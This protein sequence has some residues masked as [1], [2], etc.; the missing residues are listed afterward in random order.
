MVRHTKKH[1][2]Q[3]RRTGTKNRRTVNKHNQR[4]NKHNTLV[5]SRRQRVNPTGTKYM[6]NRTQYGGG[7]G[8]ND[9]VDKKRNFFK[10]AK[11]WLGKKFTRKNR[12]VSTGNT[13][14]NKSNRT[15]MQTP[16]KTSRTIYLPNTEKPYHPYNKDGV[17]TSYEIYK[18]ASRQQINRQ[19]ANQNKKTNSN[20]NT[21]ENSNANNT[22]AGPIEKR[23][24]N[25]RE[26]D[27]DVLRILKARNNPYNNPNNSNTLSNV[28]LNIFKTTSV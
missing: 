4:Q 5:K 12:N 3:R 8:D 23:A 25:Y 7:D 26:M 18:R 17:T 1:K 19:I 10:R 28:D 24:N 21:D 22:Y 16:G 20:T 27:P 9:G 11:G 14:S 13:N 15:N 6:L 2:S